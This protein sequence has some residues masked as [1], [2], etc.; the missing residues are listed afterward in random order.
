[1]GTTDT[2]PDSPI[3][4]LGLGTWQNTDFDQCRESV[5]TA[6][7]VGYRHVDTAE[8][9]ENER[10]VGA[11]VAAAGVPREDVYLATKVLHPREA[12]DV[13]RASIRA[14]VEGCLDRL[15]VDAVDL[16]YV[17]W[18]SDYDLDLV[19]STLAELRDDGLTDGVGV[20]NYEPEHVDTALET[21]PAILANQVECH[22]LLPQG[23]LREHCADVGVDVVAYA[24]LA[25]GHVF[26]V[27]ELQSVAEDHGVSVPRVTLAWLRAKGV[28]AVPKA[29]SEAHV[30]DNWA[31]RDLDLSD[32][33]VAT[34]DGIER[35]ERFFDPDYAPD[36]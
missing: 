17:H 13:T 28:A 24:P 11:G 23:D 1:M 27:P 8:L 29:T 16:L 9:Y 20:S 32:A 36:W 3:P 15:A 14:A 10:P 6:I 2:T 19:H 33:D 12:G 5:R 35:T 7:E 30:R 34:I 22:P 25:H 31:S 21:D 18:P 26:D 4:R